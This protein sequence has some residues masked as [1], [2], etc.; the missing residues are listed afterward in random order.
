MTP[1]AYAV[2]TLATRALVLFLLGVAAW[3]LAAA[4]VRG[5]GSGR[6]ATGPADAIVVPGCGVLPDG[7]PSPALARRVLAGV[8]LWKD[9]AAPVL[10][11]SGANGEAHAA[12][13]MAIELGVPADAVLEETRATH[14]VA[15]ARLS[16][17][18][19]PEAQRIILTTDDYHLLR[20]RLAFRS[21]FHEVVLHDAGAGGFRMALR[22]VA[23]LLLHPMRAWSEQD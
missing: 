8:T 7:S 14:T 20:A 3:F 13:N 4:I 21:H 15:N 2:R 9:G 10:L 17:R 12:A 6:R 5:W 23:G 22:E 19:L 11:F 16:A 18:M 1:N